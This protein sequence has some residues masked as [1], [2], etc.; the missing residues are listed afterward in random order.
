MLIKGIVHTVSDKVT[1]CTIS[2]YIQTVF[3]LYAGY[4]KI[5]KPVLFELKIIIRLTLLII[6]ASEFSN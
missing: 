2:P 4:K 1:L 6:L 3:R 5:A